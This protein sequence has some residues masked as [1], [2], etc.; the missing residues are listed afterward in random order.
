M[1]ITLECMD[2]GVGVFSRTVKAPLD[3]T[4]TRWTAKGGTK[5]DLSDVIALCLGLIL[6]YTVLC[7][8]LSII[9]ERL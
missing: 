6:F 8:D 1:L 3:A 4:D 7:A 2:Y 5:S 9:R